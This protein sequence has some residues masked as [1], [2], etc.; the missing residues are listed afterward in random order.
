M[1]LTWFYKKGAT[2]PLCVARLPVGFTSD[3]GEELG[4]GIK[5]PEP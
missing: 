5:A 4:I 2:R 3:L 1:L